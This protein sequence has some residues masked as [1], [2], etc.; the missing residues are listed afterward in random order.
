MP[1]T[2]A[3]CWAG[4]WRTR[5]PSPRSRARSR[6]GCRSSGTEQLRQA[7]GVRGADAL[8]LVLEVAVH[9]AAGG[10]RGPGSRRPRRDLLVRVRL[11]AQAQVPERLE[12]VRPRGGLVGLGHAPCHAVLH[13]QL[14]GVLPRRVA[15][16]H[17]RSE[18][19][20]SELQSPYDLVC[21]LLLEKK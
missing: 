11:L 3:T 6:R 4:R 5:K 1:S 16:L 8:L 13:E 9:V 20:T 7:E 14:P 21:R 15:E 10:Q 18:E 12:R 17:G 2:S 19:H